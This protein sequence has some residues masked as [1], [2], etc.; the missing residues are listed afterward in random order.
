MRT[1]LQCQL[2]GRIFAD[3]KAVN[4]RSKI[5]GQEAQWKMT[6]EVA[7]ALEEML[8]DTSQ[9]FRGL[10]DYSDSDDDLDSLTIVNENKLKS[11]AGLAPEDCSDV[12]SN[13]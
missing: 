9:T 2:E 13:N 3:S 6:H 4:I 1:F 10:S 7:Y 8:Q 11:R 12:F 5:T